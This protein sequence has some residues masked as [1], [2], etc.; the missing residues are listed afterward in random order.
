MN[1]LCKI[2]FILSLFLLCGCWGSDEE[3]P[4]K[5]VVE[6]QTE[7]VKPAEEKPVKEEPVKEQPE[8]PKKVTEHEKEKPPAGEKPEPKPVS[9]PETPDAE[10]KKALAIEDKGRRK[11]AL[12]AFIRKHPDG[13]EFYRA[14]EALALIY[15]EEGEKFKALKVL[16]DAYL[17]SQ[18][19]QKRQEWAKKMEEWNRKVF[20]SFSETPISQVYV[21]QPGDTLSAIGSRFNTPYRFIMRMNSIEN[22]R[23]INI[24]DRIKVPVPE[25]KEKMEAFLQVDRSEH[26]LSVFINGVF[27][28]R[29]TVGLGKD[30]R[31]PLGEFE[32]VSKVHKPSWR[33]KPYGHPEN[34]IGDWW[35]GF[36]ESKFKG[37]GIHGTNDPSS[38]G[39]DVSQG[40][41]RMLNDDVDELANTVPK[42]TRVTI[43]K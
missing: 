25:G 30:D 23:R 43:R 3:Q 35:L 24:G 1:H 36:D 41:I 32:I 11:S 10:L 29:Y 26:T 8:E 28:K 6:K 2:L 42:G 9:E 21:I 15:A 22:P 4:P 34:I 7:E 33:G 12:Q 13:E 16:S 39:K 17:K 27:L 20:F 37:L 38:I 40:C 19:A 31:T 18:D 5:P 14:L